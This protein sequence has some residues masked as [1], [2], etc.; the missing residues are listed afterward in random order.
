M[1]VSLHKLMMPFTT[2]Q[3]SFF[4]NCSK[5]NMVGTKN[6]SDLNSINISLLLY[7]Q[8]FFQGCR[9]I[10]Y[11]NTG[12]CGSAYLL[13]YFSNA[14]SHLLKRLR[15]ELIFAKVLQ[16]LREQQGTSLGL[17]SKTWCHADLTITWLLIFSK[18]WIKDWFST[19]QSSTLVHVLK[20]NQRLSWLLKHFRFRQ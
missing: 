2:P 5:L 19:W 15:R 18:D 20:I 17:L 9:N 16:D 10:H 3:R 13:Q 11:I 12:G 4:V 8:I 6:K 14:C 1:G 7:I